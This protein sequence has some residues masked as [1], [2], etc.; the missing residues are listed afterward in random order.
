VI[1][2][3]VFIFSVDGTLRAEIAEGPIG[4]F[5][6]P[7]WAVRSARGDLYVA[8]GYGQ[9]CVHRLARGDD[10]GIT[11]GEHGTEVGQFR[12]PHGIRVD[13]EER[14]IVI[15]RGN[16]RIQRFDRDGRFIDAW[17]GLGPANDA[18]LD[19]DDRLY[20][21]EC[22]QRVSILD[23]DG[24]VLGQLTHAEVFKDFLHGLWLDSRGS[25][26]VCEVKATPNRLLK[27]DPEP[28]A[29]RAE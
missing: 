19:H 8:G 29:S 25:M 12:V 23:T 9:D 18:F 28:D 15:D 5:C 16:S 26:Y 24:A 14:V 21:A 6:K 4:P 27:L 7:T 10:P 2:H 13:S 11:W 17:G 22:D 20:V 1:H 3:K